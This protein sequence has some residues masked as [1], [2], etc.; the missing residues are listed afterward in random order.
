MSE[1]FQSYV[2]GEAVAAGGRV[3]FERVKAYLLAEQII[4]DETADNTLEG[5]GYKPGRHAASILVEDNDYWRRLDWKGV[6]FDTGR[7]IEISTQLDYGRCPHCGHVI[8]ALSDETL[9][10][11]LFAYS[12]ARSDD[13]ECPHCGERERLMRWDF[14]HGL[15]VGSA[16][17]QF[18][19]WPDH[20]AELASRFSTISGMKC[21]KVWG[22][23]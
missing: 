19:N 17:A 10:D 12:E 6:K 18:W 20:I 14:G 13:F 21:T 1:F 9:S 3:D 2:F 22:R 4:A 8:P 23:I 5:E 15:A 7:V 11:A 16:R